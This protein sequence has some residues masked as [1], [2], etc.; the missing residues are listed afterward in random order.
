MSHAELEPLHLLWALLSETGLATN[1]L[2]RLELDPGLIARTVEQE[3]QSLPTVA[4]EGR[5]RPQP[6]AAEAAAGGREAGQAAAAAWSAP[7]SCC[8]PWP[9]ISGRAGSVLKTFDVTAEKLARAL[10]ASGRR[11]GL[12][13]RRR[14]RPGRRPGL[15]P[16]QVRP[17]PVRRRARGQDR[18]HH[19]PRR[20]DPPRDPDPQ[21]P[22]QEQPRAH[23]LARRGQ[24]RRGRGPGPPPGRGRRARG[25][26][27]QARAAPWTWAR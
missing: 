24:D 5:A 6:R 27:G 12:P 16:G 26:E 10:E 23:R 11:P 15:G 7:A 9:P 19:R 13:G 21:P 8:W 3:L 22:H 17:R 1:T 4:A 14:V 18:S 25:P 2:R 20:G